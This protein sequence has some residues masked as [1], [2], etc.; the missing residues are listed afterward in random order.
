MGADLALSTQ[1]TSYRF[2]TRGQVAPDVSFTL[3]PVGQDDSHIADIGVGW[4]GVD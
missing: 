4:S 1:F 3:A 2:W